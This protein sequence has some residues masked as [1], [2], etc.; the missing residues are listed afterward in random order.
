MVDCDQEAGDVRGGGK[1]CRSKRHRNGGGGGTGD[2]HGGGHQNGGGSGGHSS[3]RKSRSRAN[4]NHNNSQHDDVIKSSPAKRRAQ[5]VGRNV[6]RKKENLKLKKL[7]NHL[8]WKVFTFLEFTV[9]WSDRNHKL[10]L[11]IELK[12][13]HHI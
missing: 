4:N 7:K 12:N 6:L 10:N 13:Y 9:Q 2:H 1:S 11:T 3:T 8:L 5:K